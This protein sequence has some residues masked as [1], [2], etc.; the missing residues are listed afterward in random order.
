M[1]ACRTFLRGRS[2]RLVLAAVLLATGVALSGFGAYA[3]ASAPRGFVTA[4][5][6]RLLLD[7]RPYRFTGLNYYN[8]N[9]RSNCGYTPGDLGGDLADWGPGDEAMRAWFFQDLATRT[10][11]RD[12]AAFDHTLAIARTHGIKVI[13][14]LTNQWGDCEEEPGYKGESWY[15]SGYKRR[16]A[17]SLLPAAYRDYVAQIVARYK[18]DPT[19][20]AW[21]LVN[22]AEDATSLGGPC[23]ST[24]TAT[25]K[26]F[27]AD[28][29]GL[30]KSIDPNH[31]VS[32]GT[33]GGGQ[34]GAQ[35]EQYS[36]LHDVASIDLCEYHD[37]GAP[38]DPM[39]GDAWN[40]LKLRITQ[41]DE[42]GKP[43]FVGESGIMTAAVGGLQP[44]AGA[45]QAQL[46]AQFKAGV[47]GFLP[48]AWV[49]SAH[50]G[51][52]LNDDYGIGPGDP[53]LGVLAGH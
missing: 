21:Q 45:F 49:D 11:V 23:T 51:S 50:G 7:G 14:T 31:L 29:S 30:I 1:H 20:L 19:I 38:L 16:P 15:A 52:S 39:P 43:L 6:T 2:G 13:A 5:G 32:L 25:L 27:A 46:D 8:A 44:R 48:W 36:V 53:V 35:G 26:A 42:L 40:G 4:E 41:C 18:D 9:S 33:M 22:E 34:C 28:V 10:G 12:W 37:Y 24:G 17:G 47:V 3:R